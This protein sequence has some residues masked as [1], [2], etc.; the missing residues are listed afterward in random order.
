M[1]SGTNLD[2]LGSTPRGRSRRSFL[3]L[4][5]LGGAAS[6]AGCGSSGTDASA[7]TEG[8]P[9]GDGVDDRPDYVEGTATGT[10][11]LNFLSV[12]DE[13]SLN[14]V[15]LALDG[16]YAVTPEQ[17]IFP[18]WADMSTD[19]GRVYTVE[20][21]DGLEWGA[22]YGP[23]TADDWIYTI[24]EVFQADP[25]W[26]GFPNA[27]QWRQN[28]EP[29][30][31]EKT[32][33][34]SFEIRLQ[35]VDPAF[36][37][38]PVMWG[39]PCMPK[40]LIERYRPDEDQEGLQQDEDVQT[41]AY[42]GNLG[43]YRFERWNRESEFV[44]VRNDEYYLREA[45]DVP[46]AW[47][48]APYF[49]SY[50]YEVVPEESTRLSA[51]RTGELTATD[52]PET[53][54]EQFEDRDDI[55]VKVF[56]QAYMT[57]LIYNQRANGSFYEALR[58]PSVRRALAH[59]V[60]KRAIV[61]EIL[62]GYGNVA[63]T[64]QPTFS[65]WY[66]DGEV[67]EYG[68]GDAYSHERAREFL[69]SGLDATPY[70]YDGERV[71]DDDGEQVTLKL[72]FAQGSQSVRTTAQLVAQE[73]DAVGLD[74]E[75]TGKEYATL[76]EHHLYNGWQGDDDPPWNAG[77]YNGGPRDG[78]LSQEPWDLILGVTFNTY[79]RTPS[80]IRGFTVERGGTNF[81]GYVP[82]TDF[83]SLFERATSTV[84]DAERR[85][86]L[87][88]IFGALS[89]EQ[90]FNFL[91]MG[92]EIVGYDSAVRGPEEVFGYTWDRNTWRLGTP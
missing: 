68:V 70:R 83:A 79:P 54:V 37:L 87:S 49:D 80:S 64:F 22:G 66:A 2:D 53:R 50:T 24:T 43:P 41:L 12:D 51:L 14:R 10:R 73:Y 27:G 59:A 28:G 65:K 33:P 92:V 69:E 32:G 26:A 40:A 5:G 63:H 45:D 11:T 82:E 8:S 91:N 19:E 88:E 72:V 35:S 71:V 78:S 6:L 13:P 17:E 84:D 76:V 55:D 15:Q 44:A 16:P 75:L 61:D 58:E 46:E 21:R 3:S 4:L 38:R 90:P 77:P 52:V 56:P 89:A 7:S 81:Y 1:P 74:V 86:T 23:M 57:S 29:I 25:N 36:P 31:V 85:E 39:Q 20:L 30:P 67:T 9:D 62:R 48:D 42:A 60:D 18:L 47:R 34:R